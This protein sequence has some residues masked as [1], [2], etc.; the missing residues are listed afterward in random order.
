MAA[1]FDSVPGLLYLYT[2]DERLVRWNR[3]HEEMTGYTSEELL[4]S[5]IQNWFANEDQI[6]LA[7]EF[8]KVL[9]EESTL[10][11]MNLKLKNG[12]KVP[13]SFTGTK[14]I[15]DGKSYLV[16]IGINIL[17]HR[18][19]E[20]ALK[21]SVER[22]RQVAEIAGEFIWEV[23]AKG[24]YTYASP[25]VEKILGYTPEELVGK[26]HFYDLFD[27]SVREELKTATF[28]VFA[29]RQTFRYLPNPSVSKSGKIVHLE[30]SGAPILDSAG[31]LA[32][33]RG[34]RLLPR[35]F[36]PAPGRGQPGIKTR[37]TREVSR[38]C[39]PL[40]CRRRRVGAGLRGGLVANG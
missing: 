3:Q 30:T 18:K 20:A 17:E 14:V 31:N 29:E 8:S 27:L 25:L 2:A 10:V 35:P 4:N 16:G 33:Y 7:K 6:K 34:G 9:S 38:R 19:A 5:P 11:E 32:G 37:T 24:L 13:Y 1:V 22:F 28:R 39:H 23:D 40:L 26:K 36:H 12:E 15:I 21:E